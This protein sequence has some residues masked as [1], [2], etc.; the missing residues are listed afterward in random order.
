[1]SVDQ[2]IRGIGG[3]FELVSCIGSGT[4]ISISV[5]LAPEE[6]DADV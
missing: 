3:C 2:Q 4:T 6:E 5:P 1:M